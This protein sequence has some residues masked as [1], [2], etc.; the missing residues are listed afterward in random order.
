MPD[1]PR[2]GLEDAFRGYVRTVRNARGLTQTQLGRRAEAFGFRADQTTIARIESGARGVGLN[3]AAALS[4][5]LG[6]SLVDIIAGAPVTVRP[7]EE[8]ENYEAAARERELE[9]QARALRN[10]MAHMTATLTQ[11][12]ALVDAARGQDPET[13]RRTLEHFAEVDPIIAAALNEPQ[14]MDE[15]RPTHN[16]RPKTTKQSKK[17]GTGRNG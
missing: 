16:K 1:E 6:I 7:A 2:P 8:P 15:G 11:A 3:E 12:N 10:A 17:E 4:L 14:E 5:A 13:I 9:D